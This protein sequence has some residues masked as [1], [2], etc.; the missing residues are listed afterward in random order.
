MENYQ[1]V[2][3]RKEIKYLLSSE[4][5]NA[6]LPILEAHM[7]PDAFAHNSIS[8]LYY[9]TPDFRMV[10][11]SLEKPMYKEK[12]RLRSYGTP[13]NTSTVFPEIKKKAMGIVYKRRISLPYQE[14]VSF[15][16]RQQIA[17]TDTCDGTTQQ[18]ASTDTCDGTTQQIASTEMCD[19][20]TRQILHELDW[21]LASYENL[22]PRVFLS[23]ERDSYKGISD[24]SLRLT[25]DQ[26][27]LFRTDRLDL[28]EG[29]FSLVR[30]RSVPGTAR[31]IMAIFL[32]M[33]TGL[34]C[35]MGYVLLAVLAAAV[36]C[37]IFFLQKAPGLDPADRD[38]R[39][40]VPEN[41]DYADLFTDLFENYTT[42]S[43]LV[44]VKTVN[45]GSLYSL[46]YRVTLKDTTLEKELLDSMRCR[47][48]NLEV[49]SG[50]PA[51]DRQEVKNL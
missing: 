41:L 43:Q 40:V 8:N 27:I 30:F 20:T 49:S 17:S 32:A 36:T 39:V 42:A 37:L 33:N 34:C 23:Y 44:H 26:D 48:G 31:D 7:E 22:S 10:R 28:R 35:G 19:G 6:L 1:A 50:L 46:H 25:L 45:M 2:F 15:L 51:D 21:M 16:S 11:R 4:E 5:R 24:P 9:D 47:N 14:A 13:E 18:I 38:I 29:A 3:K 12:L